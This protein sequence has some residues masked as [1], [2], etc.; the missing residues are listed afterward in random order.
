MV[1]GLSTAGG[2]YQGCRYSGLS[3]A[4]YHSLPCPIPAHLDITKAGERLIAFAWRAGP[5]ML[6]AWMAGSISVLG[7]GAD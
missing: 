2:V 4:G 6:T 5:F 1:V 7:A 3:M